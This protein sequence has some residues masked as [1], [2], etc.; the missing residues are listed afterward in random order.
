MTRF[1][2]W[3]RDRAI[4]LNFSLLHGIVCVNDRRVLSGIVHVIRIGMRWRDT[5]SR[6]GPH[7]TL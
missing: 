6:Y 3:T 2:S 5:P 7:K 4:E 1:D